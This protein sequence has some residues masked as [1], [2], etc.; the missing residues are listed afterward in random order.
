M[1]C[2]LG[3][4]ENCTFSSDLPE[5][6]YS[7]PIMKRT[8]FWLLFI[9]GLI[10]FSLPAAAQKFQPKTIQFKGA[11]EYSDQELLAAAGLK[12]GVILA[13]ADMKDHSQKLMDTGIFET[14]SFKFDGVDLIFTLVPHADLYPLRLDNLPLT[15]GKE[16]DDKLHDRIPLYHGKVPA[17]GGVTDQVCRILEEMLAAEGIKAKVEAGAFAELGSR[18]ATAVTFSIAAPPVRVGAIHLQGVSSELQVRVQHA[19]ESEKGNAFTT[20]NSEH[21]LEHAIES[22]YAKE[23]YAAARAHAVRSGDPVVTAEA[24]DIPFSATVEE[25][26]LYKLGVIHLP[27][28]SVVSQA[29]IDKV[30]GP[31]AHVEAKGIT[32]RST[33][34]MISSRYKSKG[35]LDCKVTPHP[36]FNES[37]STVDYTV[38][39]DPGP[40]YHLAFV[41]FDNVSDTL[42]SR[43]MHFWQMLPGDPFDEGYLAGFVPKAMKEDPVLMRSMVGVRI[44]YD[45]FANQ[46]TH[47]VNCVLHFEKAQQKP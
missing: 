4:G 29:D 17:E 42:R 45:V 7:F 20:G 3:F 27:P 19:A 26:R 43:L 1:F 8:H 36:E 22:F 37:A 23:G 6:C 2:S 15:P 24:I 11:P 16:L 18:K 12:K 46:Q 38:E 10:I 30:T 31:A 35:Y 47:E 41:K 9:I 44:T 33:W 5:F 32:L 13:Y 14:L 28:N 40:V 34:L 21:N 25:G 39:V